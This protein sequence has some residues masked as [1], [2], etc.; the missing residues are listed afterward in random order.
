VLGVVAAAVACVGA[1]VS[2]A[3]GFLILGIGVSDVLSSQWLAVF[4]GSTVGT[5]VLLVVAVVVGR[6]AIGLE[7]WRAAADTRFLWGSILSVAAA[8]VAGSETVLSAGAAD[9]LFWASLFAAY[10][11][12]IRWA[13]WTWRY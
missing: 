1:L 12:L 9:V 11:T 4:A 6:N 8:A 3:L 10:I 2:L 13:W 7:G 5:F